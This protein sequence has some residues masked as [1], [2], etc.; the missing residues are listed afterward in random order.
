MNVPMHMINVN[1]KKVTLCELESS[2]FCWSGVYIV[3]S[4]LAS[5]TIVKAPTHISESAGR[6][7][8]HM[9]FSSRNLMDKNVLKT[10][11]AIMLVEISTRSA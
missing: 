2:A 5:R 8:F 7:Y 3:S 10:T 1:V 4:V 6:S 9:N 11:P